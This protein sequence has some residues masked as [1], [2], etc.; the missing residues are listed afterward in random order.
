[1]KVNAQ[2]LLDTMLGYLGF[3]V[4]VEEGDQD[5]EP[6]L[7]VVTH[8]PDLLVGRRGE[9]LD[10][11]QFLLNKLV[12]AEDP[13][14]PRYHVDVDHYR[15]MK[16]DTL[17]AKVQKIAES[18]A[19]TGKA[20]QL[21]PMNSYERRIVHQALKDHPAVETVSPADDARV[22]RLIIRPSRREKA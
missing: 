13:K 4:E 16:K 3:V 10:H 5:G 7:Q 11:L 21:E 12:H 1:M 15:Q 2:E 22:K 19:A 6:L 17:V 9:T 18:V 8:E 20:V 14:A